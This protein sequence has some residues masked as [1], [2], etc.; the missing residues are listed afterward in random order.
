MDVTQLSFFNELEDVDIEPNES[1][2]KKVGPGNT[3]YPN[4][5]SA[6]ELEDEDRE[7]IRSNVKDNK[8][9]LIGKKNKVRVF[10]CRYCQRYYSIDNCILEISAI[11]GICN[12]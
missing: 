10:W 3:D 4:G 5:L 12:Q 1:E 8:E 6:A 7:Y 2:L 9:W 11:R